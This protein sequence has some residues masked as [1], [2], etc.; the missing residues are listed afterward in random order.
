MTVTSNI[1]ETTHMKPQMTVT[2]LVFSE[3]LRLDLGTACAGQ[4]CEVNNAASTAPPSP[5]STRQWGC[6][7]GEP[8]TSGPATEVW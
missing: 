4:D 1:L 5:K 2:A 8:H 6:A 3:M 7:G